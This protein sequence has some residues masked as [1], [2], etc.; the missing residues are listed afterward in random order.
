MNVIAKV[1]RMLKR[2]LTCE[3]ANAFIASYLDGALDDKTAG[4]FRTHLNNCPACS[5]Y[6]DQYR[7]TVNLCQSNRGGDA[8]AE[9]VAETLEFLRREW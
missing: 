3:D 7:E 5:G 1:R 4:R 9:L 6:L 2:E 8:P